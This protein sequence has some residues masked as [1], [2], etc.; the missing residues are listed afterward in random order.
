MGEGGETLDWDN[1]DWL[2]HP[3]FVIF[4]TWGIVDM[5]S[6]HKR[7]MNYYEIYQNNQNLRRGS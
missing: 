5:I 4:E 2:S 3:G 7:L 1:R 6:K